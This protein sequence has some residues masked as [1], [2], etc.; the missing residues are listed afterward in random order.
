MI[1]SQSV[2]RGGAIR[3]LSTS[4]KRSRCPPTHTKSGRDIPGVLFTAAATAETNSKAVRPRVGAP[5]T[6]SFFLDTSF[7]SLSHAARIIAP[8]FYTTSSIKYQALGLVIIQKKSRVS[9][10]ELGSGDACPDDVKLSWGRLSPPSPIDV[11][12]SGDRGRNGQAQWRRQ[13]PSQEQPDR[14]VTIEIAVVHH[15]TSRLSISV[16]DRYI[17]YLNYNQ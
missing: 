15:G 7:S 6:A 11:Q 1:R 4:V 16:Q 8:L 3:Y 2:F 13:K 5:A 12:K 17:K 14:N 10:A 9:L